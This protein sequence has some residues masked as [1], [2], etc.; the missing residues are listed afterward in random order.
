MTMTEGTVVD[1]PLPVGARVEKDQTVVVIESEKNEAE[2]E[3]TAPG[4]FRH[5]SVE[6]AETAP[7]GTLLGAITDAPDEPFDAQA[8]RRE[9]DLAEPRAPAPAAARAPQAPR[10]TS[11]PAPAGRRTP[12][13]PAARA[14]ARALGV[15]PEGIPGSGPGGRVTRQDVEAWAAQRE[16]LV[17]ASG[18]VRLEVPT[19]GEGAPLLLL[20]GFGSDASSFALQAGSL[21]ASYRVL[22]VNP[23]GVGASDAPPLDVYDVATAA[24][25]A[26]AVCPEPAHWIGASLGA[27]VALEAAIRHPQ[28]VRSLVLITPFVQATPR[29]RAVTEA[30]WRVARDA[31]AE[32]L[33]RML[34]PWLFS[35]RFL[36]D[37]QALGRTLRGL[38]ASVARVPAATLERAAAGLRAW[39]GTRGEALAEIHV[40]TLVLAA[41]GDLLTPG[42]EA[43]ARAMP[44]ARSVVVPEAGHALAIEAPDVVSDAIAAHLASVSG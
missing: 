10:S 31:S 3:A 36:G 38:S 8:F 18:G 22:G 1:W 9:N 7:C 21:A 26:A 5:V 16:S 44:N 41:G 12:V 42:G 28:R 32:T 35:E 30:W 37:E 40:P 39:S 24:D 43:V 4:F 11:A 34:L 6:P 27:A 20:P 33:A 25:D 19:Q 15:E 13:A 23:R 29:L 14:L 17:E 2:I